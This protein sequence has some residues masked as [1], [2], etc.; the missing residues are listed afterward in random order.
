MAGTVSRREQKPDPIKHHLTIEL[1]DVM[2]GVVKSIEVP[3]TVAEENVSTKCNGKGSEMK[4]V[5]HGP[6]MMQ[7]QS[8]CSRCRGQGISYVGERKEQNSIDVYIP[9]GCKDGDKVTVTDEGDNLPG[10]ARG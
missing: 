7:T 4:V 5:R 10:L 6:V 3:I 2:E 1:E 8:N 9:P